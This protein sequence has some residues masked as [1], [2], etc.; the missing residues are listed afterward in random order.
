MKV[1]NKKIPSFFFI[2]VF[3]FNFPCQHSQD[4]TGLCVIQTEN[5]QK[6]CSRIKNFLRQNKKKQA[7]QFILRSMKII[8]F[9]FLILLFVKEEVLFTWIIGPYIF[10]AFVNFTFVFDLL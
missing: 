3:L 10:D 7:F 9:R 8:Q 1:R 5:L 6:N 4:K 2:N